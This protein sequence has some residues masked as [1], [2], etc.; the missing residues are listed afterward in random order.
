MWKQQM[1]SHPEKANLVSDLFQLINLRIQSVNGKESGIKIALCQKDCSL[2]NLSFYAQGYSQEY[3]FNATF[4]HESEVDDENHLWIVVRNNSSEM[5]GV[6]EKRFRFEVDMD[7][8]TRWKEFGGYE[9]YDNVKMVELIF[10]NLLNL[11]KSM[12]KR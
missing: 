6:F 3:L 11:F 7:G 4:I 1:S 8:V 2:D 5:K 12:P 9:I 10:A